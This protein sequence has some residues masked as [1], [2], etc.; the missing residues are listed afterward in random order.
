MKI[1]WVAINTDINTKRIRPVGGRYRSK[2]RQSDKDEAE[3]DHWILLPYSVGVLQ[4]Y[5]QRHSE[6]NWRFEFLVPIIDFIPTTRAVEALKEADVVGFSVYLWNIQHSLALA[7]E[8]K[9]RNDEVITVF[10][11]PQVP[12]GSDN[13]VKYHPYVDLACHG[14]GEEAIL[15]ILE[16]LPTRKWDGVPQVSYADGDG[17]VRRNGQDFRADDMSQYPS[18]YGEGVFRKLM[19]SRP[20]CRWMALLETNRGCPYSCTFCDWG[21]EKARIMP[22]D[23][24]RVREDIKWIAENEIEYVFCCDANFGILERDVDIIEY[25]IEMKESLGYPKAFVL[26][27]SKVNP[28]RTYEIHSRLWEAGIRC[29]VNLAVQSVNPRT[30]QVLKRTNMSGDRYRQLQRDFA[31]KRITTYTDVIL[32]LPGETYDSFAEGVSS[33]ID[34]GE[35]NR[36]YFYNCTILP[37]SEMASQEYRDLHG[38]AT[39]EQRIIAQYTPLDRQSESSVPEYMQIIVAPAAM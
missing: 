30:L 4:A 22:I 13:F 8:L 21:L 5:I 2:R 12:G 28:D 19:E 6:G 14:Q 9:K 18:P 1:G 34:S 36:I 23:V 24:A 20:G 7:E 15:S 26:Q 11:G 33:I 27:N 35:H 39:V 25:L 38:I 32:G 31:S 29:D 37:N 3:P 16:N 17:I 10:G